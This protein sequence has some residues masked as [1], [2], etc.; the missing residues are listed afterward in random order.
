MANFQ[1]SDYFIRHDDTTKP[2]MR[3][4][5]NT[6]SENDYIKN[7]L[8]FT[9]YKPKYMGNY[10]GKHPVLDNHPLFR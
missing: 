9:K 4:Q 7:Q 6:V 5:R 8:Y 1:D 3:N 10:T 2:V